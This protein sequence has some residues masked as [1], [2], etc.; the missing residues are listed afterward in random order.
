MTVRLGL[1]LRL[2]SMTFDGWQRLYAGCL[3]Q[4]EAADEYGFDCIVA[5]EHHFQED[6]Y[7]PAPY[8]VLG[9]IAA[10]T[11]RVRLGAGVRP[12]PMIHP[13]RAAEDIT[14]LDNISNGRALG[15]GFGLGGRQREYS[16]FGIPWK[17]RRR[18]YEE[19]LP[20]VRRLLTESNV[21]HDGPFYPL[22]GVTVTPRAVQQ[23]HP[24]IWIAASVEPA[25]RRAAQLG[26]AWFSRP[27]ESL[28]SLKELTAIYK[29]AMQEAG[30]DWDAAEHVIRRDGWVADDD[31]TAWNEALPALRFHYTRDY[32]F[33]PNDASLEYMRQY[34]EDRF[35]IGSPETIIEKIKRYE[36][37]LG[38]TV[39]IIALD[40]PGLEPDA[41]L[42][43]IRTFGEKII[44]YV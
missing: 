10:R 32:S 22:D 8:T 14:V 6:G 37:E 43:A 42:K 35:I 20:L 27:V 18:R 3:E 25:I 30:K 9:G 1:H 29:D 11:K 28:D 17:E 41:V 38:V 4:A 44:P 24:P 40:N 26:D 34:G 36:R 33:F 31:E 7:I 39:M 23:P 21:Y 5:A 19:G 16:G 12:L 13:V 2:A 15:G